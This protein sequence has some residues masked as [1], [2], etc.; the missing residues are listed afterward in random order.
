[1]IKTRLFL[2]KEINFYNNR[3]G[4]IFPGWVS[5]FSEKLSGEYQVHRFF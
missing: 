2:E 5:L 4:V 1:M 3:D